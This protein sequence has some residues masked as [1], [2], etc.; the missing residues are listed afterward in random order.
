MRSPGRL[1][2][3]AIAPLRRGGPATLRRPGC[4]PHSRRGS[5]RG[6]LRAPAC[7]LASEAGFAVPTVTLMLVAALTMA[8]VAV[9]TS[10]GGQ[11]G[12]VR[13][14]ESKT[15][16]AVAESGA[17]QAMLRFNRHGL[18]DES[19]P[20]APV[21]GTTPDAEGWC[22][23][24]EGTSV[25]GGTVTYWARPTG[26]ELPN[27]EFAFTELEVV[28]EGT[29][30]GTVR[31]VDVTAS[32]SA[33][34]D[35]FAEYP[36]KSMQDIAVKDNA[37]IKSGSATNGTVT[38]GPGARQCGPV[39]IGLGEEL[40]GEGYYA[41]EDCETSGGGTIEDE[42]SLPSVNQGDAATN[43]DNFRITNAVEGGEPADTIS[44]EKSDLT[45]DPEARELSITSNT[46]LTLGGSVYSFCKVTLLENSAI[47]VSS[48]STTIYFDSPEACGYE[49]GAQQLEVLSNARI[50]VEDGESVDLALLFV[51][52]ST[53]RLNSNTKVGGSCQ[54]NFVV[55][56]PQTDVVL[57]PNSKFC[58]AMGVR[59]VEVGESAQLFS[60]SGTESFVLPNTAP[61]YVADRFVE[62]TAAD[63]TGPPDEDC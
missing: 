55:Y 18:A 7:R 29:L 25:N 21:G 9:S 22:P 54:Q 4:A 41:D 17:D 38:L 6:L 46:S 39:S 14:Q 51:G 61:H 13:D 62:C 16:L 32:S 3:A 45:W 19:T 58:G 48:P 42:F 63:V 36:V 5:G 30:D 50:T 47:Y 59:S 56:G 12:I 11:G 1:I 37:T 27:G 20:C 34:Q 35:M 28:A 53:V 52:E 15:A 23:A 43:N 2:N 49:A 60:S 57:E 33:G 8:G 24:V 10:V 44:G 26:S 31:R 40:E